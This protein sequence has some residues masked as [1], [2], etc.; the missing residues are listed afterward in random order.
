ME[1]PR[2]AEVPNSHVERASFAPRCRDTSRPLQ[3]MSKRKILP[4]INLCIDIHQEDFERNPVPAMFHSTSSKYFKGFID[5]Q[6]VLFI[7][8]ML[9]AWENSRHLETLPLVSP[10]N[11]VWEKSVEVPYWWLVTT[12]IWVLLLIGRAAWEIWFNQSESLPDLG[13]DASSVWN[14]CALFSDVI[15]WGNQW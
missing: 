14:F 7:V 8:G 11:D 3:H 1:G 6:S 4:S 2:V 5:C 12:Q 13:S 15:W 9:L 10:R